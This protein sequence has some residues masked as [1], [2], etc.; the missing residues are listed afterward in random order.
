MQATG[1]DGGLLLLDEISSSVDHETEVL[2][3]EIIN[4]EFSAYTVVAVAHR[5]NS[6]VDSVDRVIVLDRGR[7]I[8]QG[9]P[10]DLLAVDGGAFRELYRAGH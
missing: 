5:L 4:S 10:Q 8:E 6:L 3:Q 7:I 1:Q 9:T 2:M